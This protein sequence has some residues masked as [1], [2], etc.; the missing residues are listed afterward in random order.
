VLD[1]GHPLQV[2]CKK[3]T[4]VVNAQ[5]RTELADRLRDAGS[6]AVRS[7]PR[8]ARLNT[9]GRTARLGREV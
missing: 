4:P 8:S 7:R 5:A 9:T 6:R 2:S 3:R 1:V